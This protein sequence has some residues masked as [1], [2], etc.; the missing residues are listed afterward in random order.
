MNI[1]SIVMAVFTLIVGLSVGLKLKNSEVKKLS[2]ENNIL[3]S[4]NKTFAEKVENL[5]AQSNS[6][7]AKVEI[8]EEVQKK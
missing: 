4:E 5:V 7:R 8:L 3:K 6:D 2:E 1:L